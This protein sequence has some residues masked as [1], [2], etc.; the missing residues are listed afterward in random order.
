M[1]LPCRD[2]A[3]LLDPV[4]LHP[5]PG[6]QVWDGSIAYLDRDGVLN[7]GKKD[8]I[9][10]VDELIILKHSAK[11]VGDLRRAGYRICVVTNQSPIGRG[12][13][14]H[15]TL[16]EIHSALRHRLVGEDKDAHL[17]LILYSPYVPWAG[18]WARKPN[19][20]MLQAGRQILDAAESGEILTH[21]ASSTEYSHGGWKETERSCIVGDRAADVGAG[22]AHSVRVFRVDEKIGLAQVTERVIDSD[23]PGDD[24]SHYRK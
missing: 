15:E 17:D 24:F 8:Y 19:P 6:G 5:L 4:N 3:G 13:W 22:L 10:S 21:I 9:N 14:G 16:G 1:D 18:A 23:D 11:S 20:G 12:L 2:G 7:I